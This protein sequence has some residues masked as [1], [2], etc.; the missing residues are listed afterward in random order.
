MET[1]YP[2]LP[3]RS[4]TVGLGATASVVSKRNEG[5]R[6]TLG[7]VRPQ[8]VCPLRE[9]GASFDW[10]QRLDLLSHLLDLSKVTGGSFRDAIIIPWPEEATE[11]RF[12]LKDPRGTARQVIRA[13]E[14]VP[15]LERRRFP[16][17]PST[18]L[19]YSLAASNG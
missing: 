5:R 14:S 3:N 8:R 2:G 17:L 18:R 7:V 1:A 19:R 10:G 13:R 6:P 12:A 15:S 16:P 11:W 4:H 9:L